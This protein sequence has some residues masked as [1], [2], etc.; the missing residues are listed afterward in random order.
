MQLGAEARAQTFA[1]LLARRL[2][3][4][5][6]CECLLYLATGRLTKGGTAA[7]EASSDRAAKA[8]AQTE[9]RIFDPDDPSVGGVDLR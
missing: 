9:T 3:N 2:L 5:D 8:S 4:I 1:F 6:H 7:G